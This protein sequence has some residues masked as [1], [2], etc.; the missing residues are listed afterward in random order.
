MRLSPIVTNRKKIQHG[1]ERP[2]ELLPDF[3]ARTSDESP[4][5]F[6]G[7]KT[8]RPFQPLSLL[9]FKRIRER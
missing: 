3:R 7:D 2:S 5:L 4:H 8:P 1:F 9:T 6:Y